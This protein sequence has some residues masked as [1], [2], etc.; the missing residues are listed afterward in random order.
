MKLLERQA[1]RDT[2]IDFDE[3]HRTLAEWI[4]LCASIRR[5]D[6]VGPAVDVLAEIGRPAL[7]RAWDVSAEAWDH[8]SGAW[9]KRYNTT[10]CAAIEL[11]VS[12][13]ARR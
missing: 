7:C 11:L 2:G 12:I 6:S 1:I 8:E 10:W 5:G 3:S 13:G 9:C 4:D